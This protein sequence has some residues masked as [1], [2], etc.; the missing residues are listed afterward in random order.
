M[1]EYVMVPSGLFTL[2][3]NLLRRDAEAGKAARGEV[4]DDLSTC[5]RAAAPP[6]PGAL[7][8][9]E[10]E[11]L[12]MFVGFFNDI[13]LNRMREAQL[14]T[15]AR[16]IETMLPI[17]RRLSGASQAGGVVEKSVPCGPCKQTGV[18][19]CGED[20]ECIRCGGSGWVKPSE[21]VEFD[22]IMSGPPSRTACEKAT[23]A[24]GATPT[25]GVSEAMVERAC[26]AY[27]ADCASD[28]TEYADS[29]AAERG[30]IRAA[31][32]AAHLQD[33]EGN[34]KP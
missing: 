16:W 17:L 5:E 8:E 28:L 3:V 4:V 12:G 1:S 27:W 9:G 22:A 26:A 24:P 23:P 32:T 20:V 11:A 15:G 29:H 10:R 14:H 13:S 31:L 7:S 34:E 18:I 33:P 25:A 30:H 21:V 6:P 2:V 19:F